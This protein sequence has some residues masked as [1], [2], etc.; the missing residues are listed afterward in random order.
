M[1]WFTSFLNSSV[2]KKIFQ[3]TTGLLLCLYLSIHLA[4]NLTLFA[5]EETFNGY[6]AA[7]SSIKPLV[8]VIEVLLALLFLLH[9]YHAL[10]L[11]LEN[12]NSSVGKKIF[13]STGQRYAQ[14]KARETSSFF[15]RTMGWSGSIIFIFLAV[16]LPTFWYRFQVQ[17]SEAQ[18]YRI[19][20]DGA[21]GFGNPYISLF[22]AL[23]MVLLAF[24]LR[25]GFESAF[26]TFGIRYNK[27]GRLIEGLAVIF[28]LIIPLGFL[29]IPVYFG[30]FRGGP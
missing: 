15:S 2:G 30:F 13:R 24:H 28:W 9:L 21:V 12:R 4:G 19:V 20:M 11:T 5:G 17:H 6:V 26:Q 8:R 16:H 22:Y 1:D 10:R 23:A 27:Y 25:H 7:L 3:A 29:S 14:L 18:F